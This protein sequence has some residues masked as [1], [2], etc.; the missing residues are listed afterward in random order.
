MID[1]T[2]VAKDNILLVL[3]QDQYMVIKNIQKDI[4]NNEKIIAEQN[5]KITKLK[6]ELLFLQNEVKI[7]HDKK[8]EIILMSDKLSRA[9]DIILSMI[10]T[11]KTIQFI[12]ARKIED[13]L[14]GKPCQ[15]YNMFCFDILSKNETLFD[16]II[17]KY[18]ETEKI[19]SKFNEII[20]QKKET[21]KNEL[22]QEDRV[23]KTITICVQIT[24]TVLVVMLIATAIFCINNNL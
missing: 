18:N 8:E 15:F 14:F 6:D 11:T 21:A 22:S 3:D 1:L 4:P 17:S 10:N 24:I 16:E 2:K 9:K 5:A 13:V 19:I 7:F 20:K 23:I 12:Q